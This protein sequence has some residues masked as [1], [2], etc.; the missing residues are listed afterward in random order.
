MM[1]IST[2]VGTFAQRTS[3]VQQMMTVQKRL[4]ETQTQLSTEKKS[5]DYA[6]VSIDSFRLVSVETEKTSVQRF[7]QGNQIANVRLGTME[8]AVSGLR[9]SVRTF[10]NDLIALNNQTFDPSNGDDLQKLREIQE[11]AFATLQDVSGYLNTSTDGRYLFAGGRTTIAPVEVPYGDLDA[12][13]ADYTGDAGTGLIYPDTRPA[14]VPDIKV[15]PD[16]MSAALS[17]GGGPGA[18]TV[19]VTPASAVNNIPVGATVRLS[20]SDTS[21]T[22]TVTANAAGVLTLGEGA[23]GTAATAATFDTSGTTI[24]TVSYYR[25]DSLAIDHRVSADRTIQLGVT[26]KDPAF[27]KAVRALGTLAQGDL[28]NNLGRLDTALTWLNESLDDSSTAASDLDTVAR[29]I[30]FQQVTLN[31]AIEEA[32]SYEVFLENRQTEIENVNI[33]DAAT[34]LQDDARAL[35]VSFQSYAR[36]SQLSLQ[37]YI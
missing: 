9:E 22:Y 20:D 26:A 29:R 21:E 25:G 33:I 28:E 19:T 2:R 8:T 30:G 32:Q 13:Q 3:L 34:R 12:F 17:F 1:G 7:T 15:T 27:E 37:Q 23:N 5:Q 31:R 14:N 10:R 16:E 35:D 4:Y 11:R 18:Y 36:I 6:G 24:E